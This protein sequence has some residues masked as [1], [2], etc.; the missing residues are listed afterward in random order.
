MFF[1]ACDEAFRTAVDRL[2]RCCFLAAAGYG[3]GW[4]HTYAEKYL[5]TLSSREHLLA[6]GELP[7]K[8]LCSPDACLH[9]VRIPLLSMRLNKSLTGEII[10]MTWRI[11]AMLKIITGR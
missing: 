1:V 6:Q 10:P 8:T 3:Q 11:M 2:F 9:K 7:K 5:S 4:L